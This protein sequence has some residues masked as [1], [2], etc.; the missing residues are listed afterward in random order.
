MA[1]LARS[2]SSAAAV[3]RCVLS[4]LTPAPNFD[5]S[6]LGRA[7]A[8]RWE[9]VGNSRGRSGYEAVFT[10]PDLALRRIWPR[11]CLRCDHSFDRLS[12]QFH[13]RLRSCRG[14]AAERPY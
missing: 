10:D 3:L 5:S 11:E 8:Q 6:I 1:L 13:L 2:I 7:Q 12:D 4:H 9:A 14:A